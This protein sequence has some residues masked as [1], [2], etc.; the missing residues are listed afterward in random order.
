M[1]IY[2]MGDSAKS[3]NAHKLHSRLGLTYKS[4]RFLLRRLGE[5]REEGAFGRRLYT[6][7]EAKGANVLG[8]GPRE[9][10]SRAKK[11]RGVLRVG[12]GN[13]SSGTGVLKRLKKK[14]LKEFPKG[15]WKRF[16]RM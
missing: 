15:T 3:L 7:L 9:R 14:M 8:K 2:L 10:R 6:L 12:E 1:A 11:G 5:G 16:L 13:G 4:A